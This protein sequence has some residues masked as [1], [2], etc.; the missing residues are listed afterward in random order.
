MVILIEELPMGSRKK[1]QYN[2]GAFKSVP[3]KVLNSDSYKGL[4]YSA[5]ALLM[6][7]TLQYNGYNNGKLCAIHNQLE[8]RGFKSGCTVTAAIKELLDAKLIALSK[9]NYK[10]SRKPNYYALTWESVDH[11]SD[12]K[13]DIADTVRPL[14]W[15]H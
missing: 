1:K 4:G 14:R 12:F 7:L 13:M 15:F 11:I 5:R 10:G 6:E 3:V 8:E 2:N 9:L